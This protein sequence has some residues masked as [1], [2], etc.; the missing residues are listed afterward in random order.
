MK[1]TQ[2]Y[3]SHYA[4]KDVCRKKNLKKSD[5]VPIFTRCCKIKFFTPIVVQVIPFDGIYTMADVKSHVNPL[6]QWVLF[7]EHSV[8]FWILCKHYEV[9][10]RATFH[11]TKATLLERVLSYF[12]T[13]ITR[14]NFIEVHVFLRS[15]DHVLS[16]F[17]FSRNGDASHTSFNHDL[18][19][20]CCSEPDFTETFSI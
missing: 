2:H 6:Q 19:Y 16:D 8:Y 5:D 15:Q 3:L 11:V 20:C 14:S 17:Y 9:M 12:L 4:Q 18:K 1:T 13:I 7:I 10:C